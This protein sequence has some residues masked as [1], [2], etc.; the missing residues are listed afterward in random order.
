MF[1]GYELTNSSRDTLLKLYPPKHE[2]VICHH[3]TESYNVPKDAPVPAMP[4][5]VK[6]VG[7]IDE[8]GVEGFLVSVNGSTTRPDNKKY[9]I[10][11]SIAL[12]RKPVDT[13]NYT[14]QA[15]TIDPIDINVTPKNFW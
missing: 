15:K 1:T 6:I 10:T 8:D 5:N 9:H 4:S 12:N 14:G 11:H 2:K 7:Y 13:N 3:I